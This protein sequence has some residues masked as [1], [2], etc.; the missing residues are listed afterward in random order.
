MNKRNNSK[1][2]EGEVK[3]KKELTVEK[4]LLSRVAQIDKRIEEFKE[5]LIKVEG[6]REKQMEFIFQSVSITIGIFA[7]VLTLVIG[8]STQWN[9]EQNGKELSIF[10]LLFI[11]GL[12]VIWYIR[13]SRHIKKG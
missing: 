2:K 7:V 6:M 8:L 11:S 3:R 10:L 13:W 5:R 4:E 9:F 12:L 1:T